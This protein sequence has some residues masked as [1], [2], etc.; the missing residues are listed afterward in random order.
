MM[1]YTQRKQTPQKAETGKRNAAG[2]P[3]QAKLPPAR[4]GVP[5]RVC[6]QP[7]P[8]LQTGGAVQCFGLGKML[9]KLFCCCMRERPHMDHGDGPCAVTAMKNLGWEPDYR[10]RGIMIQSQEF[11]AEG[12]VVNNDAAFQALTALQPV[13]LLFFHSENSV[14]FHVM[15]IENGDLCGTN[16]DWDM[17]RDKFGMDLDAAADRRDHELTQG[18][19]QVLHGLLR[20]AVNTLQFKADKPQT[21]KYVTLDNYL[22]FRRNHGLPPADGGIRGEAEN[23][24]LPEP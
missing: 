6:Y 9:K 22:A 1:V 5:V 20:V 16:N 21:V 3:M 19:E 10:D 12:T 8:A 14:P 17:L 15:Y 13:M 7:S 11:G 2:I 24:I 18:D 4:G 23:G